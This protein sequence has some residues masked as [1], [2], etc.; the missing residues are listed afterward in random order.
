MLAVDTLQNSLYNPKHNF[1]CS[2]RRQ[3]AKPLS[4]GFSFLWHTL[5]M[6]TNFYIDGFNLYY[7]VLKRT[8]NKWLDLS[9]LFSKILPNAQNKQD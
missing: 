7:G 9:N 6:K 2:L 4:S 3:D 8:P 5:V 1:S